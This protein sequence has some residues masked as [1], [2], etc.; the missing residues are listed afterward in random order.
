M[1]KQTNKPSYKVKLFKRFLKDNN[2][3]AAYMRNF[4][5]PLKRPP[6]WRYSTFDD[7]EKVMVFDFGWVLS[8]TLHWDKTNE[9]WIFW[10]EKHIEFYKFFSKYYYKYR[11][12]LIKK[13]RAKK[14][15]MPA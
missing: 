3:Y 11:Y 13:A 4:N 8:K 5:D 10:N 6:A 14:D 12:G 9:G 7:L 2:L 15:K 1:K